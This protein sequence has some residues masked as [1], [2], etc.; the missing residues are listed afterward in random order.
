MPKG[1]YRVQSPGF[2]KIVYSEG[3]EF[4]PHPPFL[5]SSGHQAPPPQPLFFLSLSSCTWCENFISCDSEQEKRETSIEVHSHDIQRYPGEKRDKY[6]STLI[7]KGIHEKR[8][9][10]IGVHSHSIHRYP[11]EKTDRCSTIT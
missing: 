9:T 6:W 8:Q 7:F 10:S 4:Y 11:R 3:A 1:S 2:L 5:A